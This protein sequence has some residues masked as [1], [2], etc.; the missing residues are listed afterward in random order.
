MT[1]AHDSSNRIPEERV[2]AIL[3]RAAE[4]DRRVQESVELD[5]IRA[6]A[7]EAGISLSAVDRALEEYAA[8]MVAASQMAPPQAQPKPGRLRRWLDNLHAP[9]KLSN[10]LKYAGLGAL[11]GLITATGEV[12][13]VFCLFALILAAIRIVLQ[14]RPSG[15]ARRFLLNMSVMTGAALFFYA[16]TGDADED[17]LSFIAMVGLTLL[18]LGLIAIKTQA[19]TP[20]PLEE[21]NTT[22]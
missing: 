20:Q 8:A 22:S 7:V 4:L 16:L 10:M 17:L 9:L 13:I 2:S 6:A 15:R 1:H 18:P 14:D 21:A 12:G 19:R 11:S 5:A 3:K